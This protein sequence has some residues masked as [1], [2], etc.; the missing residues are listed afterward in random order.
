L[1]PNKDKDVK[2]ER[3]AVKTFRPLLL[4]LKGQNIP[5]PPDLLVVYMDKRDWI[6][7]GMGRC[8]VA[9]EQSDLPA[10]IGGMLVT[11]YDT[12]LDYFR[13]H[14]LINLNL[15]NK[16]IIND[17]IELKLAVTHE[18]IHTVATLSAISR[19]RSK[20]LIKRLRVKFYEKAHALY[21]Q[22]ITQLITEISD[23]SSGNY[24]YQKADSERYFPD[25]HFRLGFEDFPV[26]YPIIFEEFLFSKDNIN[27][28]RDAIINRD[29]V[30]FGTIANPILDRISQEKA[31][32][33]NF[34]KK[35]FVRILYQYTH[36]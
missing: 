7:Q 14:I 1:L 36:S 20:E 2:D 23:I 28:L 11:S 4:L 27:M 32:D 8:I 12:E 10:N 26:S 31:L 17:R 29:N 21:L 34:L 15:C 24:F 9:I 22:D 16:T 33:I 13:L 19:I 5:N 6:I 25:Q 35:Q 3:W 18:F 30:A